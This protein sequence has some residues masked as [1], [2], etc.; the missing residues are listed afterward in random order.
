MEITT[1]P[2]SI[3]YLLAIDKRLTYLAQDND[4]NKQDIVSQFSDFDGTNQITIMDMTDWHDCTNEEIQ[5]VNKGMKKTVEH[6]NDIF[7]TH[8]DDVDAFDE[9][10]DDED[11]DSEIDEALNDETEDIREYFP[12]TWL[13]EHFE[14]SKALTIKDFKTPDSINSWII[15][16][17]SVNRDFGIAFAPPTELIVKKQFFIQTILPYSI[18][19]NEI[20]EIK[21]LV[22]N[23]VKSKIEVNATVFL[24]SRGCDVYDGCT[25]SITNNSRP[26]Q[27]ITIKYGSIKKVSF[28]IKPKI[29]NQNFVKFLAKA[30]VIDNHN[31]FKDRVSETL[32]IEP[33][34]VKTYE[35]ISKNFNMQKDSPNDVDSHFNYSIANYDANVMQI[36]LE[37]SE[38]F[39]SDGVGQQKRFE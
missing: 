39:M 29:T 16:A 23:L 35:I 19:Y 3:V 22:H 14:A 21:I 9:D 2:D 1:E 12:E 25:P 36:H 24:Y 17:F 34:G 15:S 32:K 37:I 33:V 6:A 10:D 20:M 27:N 8:E 18:H 5:H 13:F 30:I 28:F 11:D 31:E 26:S 7:T 4:I 38:G